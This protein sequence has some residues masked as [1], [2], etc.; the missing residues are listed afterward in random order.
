LHSLHLT[1]KYIEKEEE[2]KQ[3]LLEGLTTEDRDRMLKTVE[4]AIA[5]AE[6]SQYT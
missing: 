2:V 1:L 4:E 5:I 6:A 3:K